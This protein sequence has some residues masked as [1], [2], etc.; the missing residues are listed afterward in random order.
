MIICRV[1]RI[2]TSALFFAVIIRFVLL[3]PIR[4]GLPVQPNELRLIY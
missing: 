4:G 2:P 1:L 3:R